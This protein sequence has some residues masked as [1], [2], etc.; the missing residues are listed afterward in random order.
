LYLRIYY[1]PWRGYYQLWGGSTWRVEAT[2]KQ[3]DGWQRL[4]TAGGVV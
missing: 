2:E 4:A 1:T 3:G